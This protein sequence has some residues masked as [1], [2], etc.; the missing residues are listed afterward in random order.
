M[1]RPRRKIRSP[2]ESRAIADS[3]A[4]GFLA[5]WRW[6]L[7]PAALALLLALLYQDPFI[8][9][10]DGL[11]YTVNSVQGHPSTMALGR[12][13]FIFS[14]HALY[15]I[16]HALFNLTAAQAYLLFKYAVI[17]QSPLVII[18]CW[19]LTRD[20]TR[21]TQAATIA[22]LLVALSPA[23]VI[24]SG[25][26]MTEIPSLLW[27]TIALIIHLRGVRSR[28]LWLMLLGAAL[29]GA[30]VNLRETVA[31]YAPWLVIAPLVC[32][33]KLGRREA[34][35][36]A[37]C[38]TVFLA[39]ALGGFAFWFLTDTGGYRAGW[40]GWLESMRQE[41]ARHPVAFRNVL[42]LA[43][44]FFLVA[45][46]CF[47]ALPAAAWQ[48][49]RRHKLSPLLA[50]AVVGLCA[51][52]LLF[53][54]YSTTI[55][56]RYLLTGLPALVPLV[57][58]YFIR[59]QT[60]KL[61]DARRSFWSAI[62]GVAF[63]AVV[64][65]LLLKPSHA[66]FVEKHALTRSYLVRLERVPPDGVLL[67][68]GQTIAVTYWRGLGLGQWEAIGT[69][70]GWPGERLVPIIEDYLTRG[71]RVF[72]DTD[73]RL[74]SPCG[75]QLEETRAIASLA[76]SFRF[77]HF[78]DSIYEIRPA[79]DETARDV[80]DLQSLLPEQRPTDVKKCAGQQALN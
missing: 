38:C 15:R 33:W 56:W 57:G 14:N 53:F 63:V 46:L 77:R 42:S 80:P 24:Y 73:P 29:L 55:N 49:W 44:Y 35:S 65:G 51:N 60:L 1:N 78:S 11:D 36:I 59:S 9:D 8:G 19:Q 54:N 3:V 25:Q 67:A 72:L 66:R 12:T 40:Y 4:P 68:G 48:E 47:V 17:A 26:V 34:L 23:F 13:L 20:L 74:W 21:S 69:G 5:A 31:F 58:D 10:W 50:L 22:A 79:T 28:R 41:T 7:G 37:L 62:A 18:A 6:W 32:G 70:G 45:P 16:A 43:V 75:W 39:L 64:L 52:L 27:L 71:R 2:D 76:S 61:G 30:G